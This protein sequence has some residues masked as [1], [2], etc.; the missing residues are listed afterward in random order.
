MMT[1]RLTRRLTLSWKTVPELARELK[2]SGAT[3]VTNRAV[4]DAC[5]KLV[6]EGIAERSAQP[7]DGAEY[8]ARHVFRLIPPEAVASWPEA[9]RRAEE[10]R[11]NGE[12]DRADAVLAVAWTR[13]QAA[14]KGR[15]LT[16]E[17]EQGIAEIEEFHGL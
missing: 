12:T 4:F 8:A 17:E 6:G 10:L 5:D 11:A 9:Q 7:C 3:G 2:R 16:A 14:K 13:M 15:E 1:E